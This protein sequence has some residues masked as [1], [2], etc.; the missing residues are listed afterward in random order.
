M[1]CGIVSPLSIRCGSHSPYPLLL[2]FRARRFTFCP[3]LLD[4]LVFL[5]KHFPSQD[6]PHL[7]DGFCHELLYLETVIDQLCFWEC[8]PHCQHHG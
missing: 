2:R 6:N 8:C 5:G 7:V 3:V 4:C 1:I